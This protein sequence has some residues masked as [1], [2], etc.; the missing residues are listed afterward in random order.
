MNISKPATSS[1]H[2]RSTTPSAV[3]LEPIRT[4]ESP[5]SQLKSLF[6]PSAKVDDKTVARGIEY[7][8]A[9]AFSM[10]MPTEYQG[11]SAP[12]ATEEMSK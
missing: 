3:P 2:S 7:A 8:Q 5:I 10:F 12:T 11:I 6:K 4:K 9:G 1:G